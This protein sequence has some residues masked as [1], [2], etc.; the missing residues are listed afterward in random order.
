M[1]NAVTK[2]FLSWL[3]TRVKNIVSNFLRKMEELEVFMDIKRKKR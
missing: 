1:F 3:W 2:S